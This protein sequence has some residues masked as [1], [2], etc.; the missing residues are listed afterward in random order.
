MQRKFENLYYNRFIEPCSFCEYESMLNYLQFK[1]L[2]SRWQNL[3]SLFLINVFKNKID[4]SIMDTV[5]LRVPTKQIR[6]FSTFNVSNV[7]RLIL[8]Q[9]ASQLQRASANLWTF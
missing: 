8:Q 3:A 7:S 6:D 2:Y 9:G 5:G 1:A 4:C